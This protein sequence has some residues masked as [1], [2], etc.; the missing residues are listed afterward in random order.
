VSLAATLGTLVTAQSAHAVGSCQEHVYAFKT[1]YNGTSTGLGLI[2]TRNPGEFYMDTDNP[3]YNYLTFGGEVRPR[4]PATFY[5]KDAAGNTVYTKTTTDSDDGGVIRQE[6]NVIYWA[7]ISMPGQRL[8]V[9]ADFHTRCGG[10][11]VTRFNV[12][13]GAIRTFPS[14]PLEVN[15]KYL[16]LSVAYAPP[17]RSSSVNYGT[18]TTLGSRRS[19]SESFQG[20]IGVSSKHQVNEV[21]TI[22]SSSSFTQR[23][24]FNASDSVDKT[25]SNNVII[26]GPVNSA[27]GIDH[28]GDRIFLWLNARYSMVKSSPTEVKTLGYSVDSRSPFHPDMDVVQVTV[29][30]LQNPSLLDPGTQSRLQRSWSPTGAL[31]TEDFN[32]I[33]AVDPFANGST[34]VDPNRFEPLATGLF[35]YK[36]ADPGSQPIT[37]QYTTRLQVASNQSYSFTTTVKVDFTTTNTSTDTFTYENLGSNTFKDEVMTTKTF[38]TSFN[39]TL[40]S[41]NTVNNTTTVSVTGPTAGYQGP[42]AVKAYQDNLFGT[43]MF[44]YPPVAT[45]RLG[46]P[47][48]QQTVTQG[49]PAT[50]LI[51]TGSDFGYNKDINFDADVI[52]LPAG[53]QASFSPA[54]VAPG[55][56]STLTVTTS[57]STPPGTYQLMITGRSELIHRSLPLTLVVTAQPFTLSAAPSSRTI[58][59]GQSTTYTVTVTPGSYN[60]PVNLSGPGGLPP[61]ASASYSPATI[62]GSGTSTL[63]VTTSSGTPSG[64]FSLKTT[65]SGNGFTQ[66]ATSGLVIDNVQDFGITVTPQASGIFAGDTALYTVTTNSINGF[67]A[68]VNLSV[69]GHPS[70]STPSFSVQPVPGAGTSTLSIATTTSTAPGDYDLTVTG[71]SGSLTHSRLVHLT[72]SPP[73]PDF[74]LSVTPSTQ[75]AAPGGSASYPVSTA[76]VGGFTGNVGLTVTGVPAGAT[77]SFAT[78]PVSAG[79]GTTLSVAVG[80]STAPGTYP[81]TVTGTSGSLTH[82]KTVN[83]TVSPPA[84]DFTLAATPASQSAPAGSNAQYPVSTSS[85]GGF[86]GNVGLTVT[87]LPSGTTAT[88]ATTPISAGSNTMLTVAVG[89]GTAMGTY[90]LTVTGTSG[91]LTHSKTVSL[92]VSAPVT[93]FTLTLDPT[94][95]TVAR[96]SGGSTTVETASVGGFADMIELTVSGEPAGVNVS[97]DNTSVFPGTSTTLFVGVQ[98]NA[99][100]GTYLL[101]ITGTSG[102]ITRSQM[103]TVAVT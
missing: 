70:G 51:T 13:V 88:F 27:D 35:D 41:T 36:P 6:P 91:G 8:Q 95:I 82:S 3:T 93:G 4:R 24:Q 18:S 9:F 39:V 90:P 21:R 65:A 83:L 92:T 29:R 12:Y 55:S 15:P 50:F 60:G 89:A 84:P 11:D 103:L 76:T 33:L 53:A 28:S 23:A 17:G 44:A 16:V 100:P 74:T 38:E 2:D 73:P 86:A 7:G 46:S 56:G 99:A 32:A 101:T 67:A 57:P 34:A 31:T 30:E 48:S 85:V 64:S 61:G 97:L 20:G 47:A 52:G 80:A 68:N 69:S 59:S 42:T 71:A 72:V 96:N 63:T 19:F 45:F 54:T 77:A 37:T 79:A 40:D 25:T 14:D 102:S 94:A 22:G 1:N 81:L 62:N 87:G 58:S 98:S 10:D 43:I 78:T 5:F 49:S 66:T 75:S 26:P